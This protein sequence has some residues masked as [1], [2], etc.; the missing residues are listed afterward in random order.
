MR[1]FAHCCGRVCVLSAS[2]VFAQARRSG[3]CQARAPRRRR[4]HC[5]SG[6]RPAPAPRSRGARRQR[7]RPLPAPQAPFPQGAKVGIRQPAGDRAAVGGRQG[8]RREGECARAEEADRRRRQG[9]GAAG[10]SA[11]AQ[12]SGSVMSDAARAQLEKE[13]ERQ[14]RRGAALRAGRAGRA[15]RTAAAAAAGIP[16]QA[17]AGPRVDLEGEGPAGAVQR[18]RLRCDLGGA[19]H[20]PDAGSREAARRHEVSSRPRSRPVCEAGVGE[21]TT[22]TRTG[23]DCTRPFA[24]LFRSCTLCFSVVDADLEVSGLP[25]L[26]SCST[27]RAQRAEPGDRFPSRRIRCVAVIV[28][29]ARSRRRRAVPGAKAQAD[30]HRRVGDRG[31]R[32]RD[33][34][35]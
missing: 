34:R 12:T 11:E 31:E 21:V 4:C 28:R 26:P 17:D 8:R 33:T 16:G 5:A 29:D 1:G 14:T 24:F 30:D 18:R 13:I 10:E 6:A 25:T 22:V 27:R 15:E 20:R 35:T 19:R 2:P 32:Q 23:C 9:Q 3:A 7:R